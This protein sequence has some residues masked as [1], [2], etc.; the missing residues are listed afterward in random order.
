VCEHLR[1]LSRSSL[2]VLL[3]LG[4]TF[5]GFVLASNVQR[6][7]GDDS[8]V[9]PSVAAGPQKAELEWTETYGPSGEEIVFSVDT[10]E[11]T[12]RGWK[13]RIGID[14]RTEVAWEL[15]PGATPEG[16]FG[17]Q[18]FESGDSTELDERNRRGT[19][20]AVRAATGYDPELPRIL[21]PGASWEGTMSAH[22]PLVAGSWARVVFG[23]LIAVGK[24]PEG[25]N[26]LVVWI[27]DEAYHL[28][29]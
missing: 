4:A 19:L 21:E 16:A 27:T 7:R 23:T 12:E 29:P 20:P 26:E 2:I 28:K 11:V 10:I 15:A 3:A 5:A 25:L 9:A 24:P 14:N 8:G 18:L 6:L 13:A 17:L 1:G 22:G